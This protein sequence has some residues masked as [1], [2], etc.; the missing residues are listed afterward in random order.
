MPPQAA[1][2]ATAMWTQLTLAGLVPPVLFHLLE[3]QQAAQP[4]E[5]VLRRRDPL[6][7]AWLSDTP[8]LMCARVCG[9]PVQTGSLEAEQGC[10]AF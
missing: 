9:S 4:G 7:Q 10:L 2:L 1:C 8:L 3:A 6:L 5:A